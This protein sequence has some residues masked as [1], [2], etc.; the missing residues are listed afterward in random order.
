MAGFATAKDLDDR[1]EK[2]DNVLATG[3]TG[4]LTKRGRAVERT[5]ERYPLLKIAR[6]TNMNVCSKWVSWWCCCVESRESGDDV[7]IMDGRELNFFS[8]DDAGVGLTAANPTL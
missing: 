7:L 4:L 5:R 8:A 6:R 3:V 1:L 2:G